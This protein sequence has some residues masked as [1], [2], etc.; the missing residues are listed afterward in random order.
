RLGG[1]SCKRARTSSQ[2]AAPPPPPPALHGPS[3]SK[4]STAPPP[5]SQ[6]PAPAPAPA[7]APPGNPSVAA[8]SSTSPAQR[9]QNQAPSSPS[10]MQPRMQTQAR[11]LQEVLSLPG[12]LPSATDEDTEE[13][14]KQ[15]YMDHIEDGNFRESAPLNLLASKRTY[16]EPPTDHLVVN[17][18]TK[19]EEVSGLDYKGWS[20]YQSSTL[21]GNVEVWHLT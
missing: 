11:S 13:L 7:P 21:D 12:P 18:V 16:L 2:A 17:N 8:P 19:Q 15:R 20:G 10:P 6:L 3:L 9:L 4:D 1:A 5:P 14:G